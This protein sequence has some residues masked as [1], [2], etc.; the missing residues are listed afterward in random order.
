M[1]SVKEMQ[2]GENNRTRMWCKVPF[3][4]PTNVEVAWRFAE[5]VTGEHNLLAF[6]KTD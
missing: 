5:E 1:C 3:E 6:K 4:L 2:V